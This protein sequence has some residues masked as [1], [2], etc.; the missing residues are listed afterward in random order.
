MVIRPAPAAPKPVAPPVAPVVPRPAVPPEPAGPAAAAAA[1]PAAPIPGQSPA[2]APEPLEGEVGLEE[3]SIAAWHDWLFRV[4]DPLQS[5]TLK[6]Y[7]PG[8]TS[9]AWKGQ[10]PFLLAAER[11]ALPAGLRWRYERA[12]VWEQ[13]VPGLNGPAAFQALGKALRGVAERAR[14]EDPGTADQCLFDS[15]LV[16][17]DGRTPPDPGKLPALPEAGI[18]LA[19][20]LAA[21]GDDQD[22]RDVL[23]EIAGYAGQ[24]GAEIRAEDALLALRAADTCLGGLV[25]DIREKTSADV[26]KPG[27]GRAVRDPVAAYAIAVERARE[28][29]AGAV[30]RL[31]VVAG[32]TGPGAARPME[33][34][35]G[36]GIKN[37]TAGDYAWSV[38]ELEKT[39]WRAGRRIWAERVQRLPAEDRAILDHVLGR[40][41]LP[42]RVEE[43]PVARLRGVG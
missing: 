4:N 20:A 35:L 19:H 32:A 24:A 2:L 26:V 3:K 21:S 25:R 18:W 30:R 6:R 40:A 43:V 12:H 16:E 41:P 28:E 23:A 8:R 37:G 9:P 17:W 5:L 29:A 31:L 7:E 1:L 33:E 42:K 39:P 10:L 14:A 34:R 36:A 27:T 38:S 15:A 11:E 13:A 22:C